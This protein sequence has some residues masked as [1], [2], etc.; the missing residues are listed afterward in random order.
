MSFSQEM[1]QR[2]E[3]DMARMTRALIDR[4]VEIGGAY[5][6]P[7]RP[8]ATLDQLTAAYPRAAEFARV[9]RTLDPKL[10]LRNNLWDSYLGQV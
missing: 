7:Y 6:L 1:T 5:Y 8:H 4:I 2:G 9:K 10:V 3:A